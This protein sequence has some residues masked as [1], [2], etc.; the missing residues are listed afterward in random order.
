MIFVFLFFVSLLSLFW[1]EELSSYPRLSKHWLQPRAC[2]RCLTRRKGRRP[3]FFNPVGDFLQDLRWNLIVAA[4]ECSPIVSCCRG[5][6]LT[7]L[8][9]RSLNS[10]CYLGL[11]F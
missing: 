11:L 10:P 3:D 7:I 8:L 1:G 5:H 2:W 6:G 9:H 4:T